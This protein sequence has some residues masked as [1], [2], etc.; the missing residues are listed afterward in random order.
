MPKK[1]P[2]P[3][4]AIIERHLEVIKTQGWNIQGVLSGLAPRAYTVG[5]AARTGGPEFLIQGLPPDQVNHILAA[6]VPDVLKGVLKPQLD[7]PMAG[8]FKGI[9]VRFRELSQ[10]EAHE[11]AAFAVA[12]NGGVVPMVWQMLWPDTLGHYPGDP[13]MQP[14]FEWVQK[15]PSIYAEEVPPGLRP[16]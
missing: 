14:Q 4:N 12:V 2:N 7:V 8:V 3:Y 11:H 6:F 1:S 16:N 10:A 5:L 15:L 9:D 13:L